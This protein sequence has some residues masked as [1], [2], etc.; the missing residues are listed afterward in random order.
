METNKNAVFKH[1]KVTLKSTISQFLIVKDA[2]SVSMYF[3]VSG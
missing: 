1:S 2:Q 3:A